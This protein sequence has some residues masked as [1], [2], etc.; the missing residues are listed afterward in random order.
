MKLGIK[1]T[2]SVPKVKIKT[3]DGVAKAVECA[4]CGCVL[5]IRSV[6][7]SLS[8]LGYAPYT[9]EGQESPSTD[10]RYLKYIASGNGYIDVCGFLPQ[11]QS[12]SQEW[13]I[14]PF[15]GGIC[16][17][18][19]DPEIVSSGC[20]E[21][22]YCGPTQINYSCTYEGDPNN[23][24]GP[25]DG[26]TDTWNEQL[27]LPYT[28]E[29][30]ASNVDAM[31]GRVNLYIEDAIPAG[32]RGSVLN[33]TNGSILTWSQE[34]ASNK[35]EYTSGS[36]GVTKTKLFVKFKKQTVYTLTDDNGSVQTLNANEGDEITLE[37]P[38]NP[39]SWTQISILNSTKASCC[40]ESILSTFYSGQTIDSTFTPNS[41]NQVGFI[42]PD[43][44]LYYEKET[45]ITENTTCSSD[46][47]SSQSFG[48]GSNSNWDRQ[49]A[50]TKTINKRTKYSNG[51]E[52][53][54]TDTSSASAS[55]NNNYSSVDYKQITD[56]EGVERMVL[57]SISNGSKNE[58]YTE[59]N[60]IISYTINE[61]SNSEAPYLYETFGNP[62]PQNTS[63]T[64]QS[65]YSGTLG[66]WCPVYYDGC[67]VWGD[68]LNGGS[69]TRTISF[70][71]NQITITEN[72]TSHENS[73]S[74][75]ENDPYYSQA[76]NNALTSK[77]KTTQHIYSNSISSGTWNNN[78]STNESLC[79]SNTESNN[80]KQ[81]K[82]VEAVVNFSFSAPVTQSP[83]T[84]EHW[85]H[86][87]TVEINNSAK[88]CPTSNIVSHNEKWTSVSSG[89]AI[90]L[91]RNIN[92]SIPSKDHSIC[93]HGLAF[94]TSAAI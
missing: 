80:T 47:S 77:V 2:G 93:A 33:G 46:F 10:T 51:Q 5:E 53:V 39:N 19:P 90:T 29:N 49:T 92:I 35:A 88:D 54:I 37:P 59:S 94:V 43:C 17:I 70:S 24:C 42:G 6:T 14:D 84:Y 87:Y 65:T 85:F 34:C 62:E 69:Y 81:T 44:N 12:V 72:T 83:V 3:T 63:Y 86:Y 82:S 20:S 31:L 52:T 75:E 23:S 78:S 25:I 67:E 64:N 68:A 66:E 57:W 60:G 58:T 45:I 32:K 22:Q 74:E 73:S 26:W 18:G 48:G 7:A 55:E 1:T 36:G 27:Q 4:C 89:G 91:S 71:G 11:K 76:T 38:L 8:H 56:A 9:C 79:A 21:L 16:Y 40:N 13:T 30:V 15:T 28:I 50:F 61:T 41:I